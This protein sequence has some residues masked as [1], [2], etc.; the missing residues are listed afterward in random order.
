MKKI[1]SF[2]L[3]LLLVSTFLTPA[4]A[5]ASTY[6]WQLDSRSA[7]IYD[8]LTD[9]LPY[10]YDT[11]SGDFAEPIVF[12]DADEANA[13][14]T[15]VISAAYDAFLRD[16]PE[17]FWL[18]KNGFGAAPSY[19][20][21]EGGVYITGVSVRTQFITSDIS[22]KKQALES[23]V[24]SIL[25]GASGSDYD[26][27]L[28][29][30][31]A[32]TSRCAYAYDAASSYEQPLVYECYGALVNGYALCE[33]YAK[34][35]KLLCNRAGI[36]CEL[37]IGTENGQSHMWNYVQLDGQYYHM[38]V[39]FDD[40]TGSYAYFLKGSGSLSGYTEGG[41]FLSGSATGLY[42]PN[43]SYSDYTGSAA[44]SAPPAD[45][46]A[47]P[48]PDAPAATDPAAPA[49]PDA[50]TSSPTPAE[51]EPRQPEPP[52]LPQ[53]PEGFCRVTTGFFK[54]GSLLIKAAGQAGFVKPGDILPIGT[55][56]QV[57]AI[58]NSG[59]SA[60]AINITGETT[61]LT[62]PDPLFVFT[63]TE[64]CTIDVLFGQPADPA[65]IQ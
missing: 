9:Y 63:L 26:K 59:Y 10:G 23:A 27:V 43:I 18:S 12:A 32:I 24:S 64:S 6:R 2:I 34:A 29:F 47:A 38:D 49:A 14:L 65:P 33:G 28:Y 55:V 51:P 19:Y 56:L 45:A 1:L 17:V 39:T 15:G 37:V 11:F 53:I 57:M 36:P 31:D 50:P 48:A 52:V 30:H 42:Y 40:T 16:Y 5:S 22:G 58:P 25:S 4:F 35:F 8:L 62:D 61:V 46:P 7:K 54:N 44:P 20:A 41:S 60:A 3:A 21:D 13:R